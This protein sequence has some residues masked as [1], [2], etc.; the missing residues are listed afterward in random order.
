MASERVE[1]KNPLFGGN[2]EAGPERHLYAVP[3]DETLDPPEY[4]RWGMKQEVGPSTHLEQRMSTQ[5]LWRLQVTD[6]LEAAAAMVDGL[7][8]EVTSS[9][10]QNLVAQQM[11][12]E[13]EN[14]ISLDQARRR[15]EEEML[16]EAS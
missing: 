7:R 1:N 16:R 5:E 6:G 4:T 8:Q 10:A 9:A 11:H 13:R 12:D 15:R 2:P 3:R 14:V